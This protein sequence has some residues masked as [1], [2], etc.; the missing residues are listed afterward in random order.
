MESN[1]SLPALQ[2]FISELQGTSPISSITDEL[3]Q[4]LY[5]SQQPRQA[6]QSSRMFRKFSS[7]IKRRNDV[8]ETHQLCLRFTLRIVMFAHVIAVASSRPFILPRPRCQ[9]V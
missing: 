3:A 6:R 5:S 4:K 1:A 8:V 9:G 2:R 7:H